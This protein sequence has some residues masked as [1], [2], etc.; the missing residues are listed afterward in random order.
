MR[1]FFVPKNISAAT[2]V[3]E[4]QSEQMID[5]HGMAGWI[6]A[7]ESVFNHPK[8]VIDCEAPWSF[9]LGYAAT[10]MEIDK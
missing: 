6:V 5:H 4:L 1:L 9:F 3:F 7:T 10:A 8:Y 2:G